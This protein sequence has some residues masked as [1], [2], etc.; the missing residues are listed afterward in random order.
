MFY[1]CCDLSN[2]VPVMAMAP[3]LFDAVRAACAPGW[4][5]GQS[6]DLV[7][8]VPGSVACFTPGSMTAEVTRDDAIARNLIVVDPGTT[9]EC[10]PTDDTLPADRCYTETCPICPQECCITNYYRHQCPDIQ[11]V[12]ISNGVPDRKRNRCCV[13]GRE[14]DFIW[15]MQSRE[16]TESYTSFSLYSP[17]RGCGPGCYDELLTDRNITTIYQRYHNKYRECDADGSLPVFQFECVSGESQ[18]LRESTL[19]R[20]D[21]EDNCL[22]YVDDVTTQNIRNNDCFPFG[23]SPDRVPL[24]PPG[25]F[26][27][28]P[29][30]GIVQNYDGTTHF[31]ISEG[32]AGTLDNRT[33]CSDIAGFRS[34]SKAQID[35]DAWTETE[36]VTTFQYGVGCFQGRYHFDQMATTRMYGVGCPRDGSIVARYHFIRTATYSIRTTS[37]EHCDRSI[38]DG[39]QRDD[40]QIILPG[41]L[42][43]QPIFGAMEML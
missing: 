11:D 3:S 12:V 29:T 7:V 31:P 9:V 43:P 28:R 37:M 1:N 17:W 10:V 42:D 16:V 40:R 8:R 13:Y 25:L 19:R 41:P 24:P 38:C 15:T 4:S 30:R 26:P 33:V 2:S 36:W 39:F 21:S 20:R 23:A 35:R 6:L 34:V 5:P 27:A 14:A 22:A 32:G 18:F